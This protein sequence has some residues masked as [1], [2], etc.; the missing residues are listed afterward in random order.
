MSDLTTTY[1]GLRLKNPLVASASPLSKKLDIVKKLEDAGASAVVMYSLF[2]EQISHE[3]RELDHYLSFGTNSFQEAMSFFPEMEH[4]NIGPEG[5]LEH[6]ARLK[7]AV[8]LPIIGSL[9]GISS[10]GWVD[11]ARRIQSAGAD[12]LELNFYYIPTSLNLTA[13][14]LEKA[15]VKLVTDI[16]AEISIPLTVKLSPFFTALPHFAREIVRAGADGLVLFNRFIQPDLDLEGQ[17]VDPHHLL[18]TSA[19]L[20]LPLRWV[21]ILYGK[22]NADLAL[23]GGVH[24]PEDMVK[25]LAA[26]AKVTLLA[27]ELIDKGPARAAE[28]I[29]GLDEWLDAHEYASVKQLIGSMSQK[30]VSDPAAFERGNYMKSLQ[31]YDNKLY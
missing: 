28:L 14:A 25:A 3:S 31:S 21:A 29:R 6:I 20:R 16:R 2:E 15:Y 11:Y 17:M 8:N 13:V 18:S 26:G 27:S 12:A 19:E 30:N 4:Y 23:T 7:K 24:T 9:N 10:G 1:L 5:Y 22:I